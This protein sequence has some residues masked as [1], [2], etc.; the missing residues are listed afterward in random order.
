MAEFFNRLS[1]NG[2]SEDRLPCPTVVEGDALPDVTRFKGP[3]RLPDSPEDMSGLRAWD[4]GAEQPPPGDLAARESPPGNDGYNASFRKLGQLDRSGEDG[5]PA[6]FS[7]NRFLVSRY[8]LPSSAAGECSPSQDS[9]QRSSAECQH[10]EGR[11]GYTD[12]SSAS[13]S[14]LEC[15]PGG[16]SAWKSPPGSWQPRTIAR[17]GRFQRT[18]TIVSESVPSRTA[19]SRCNPLR[20]VALGFPQS[21]VQAAIHETAVGKVCSR[22]RVSGN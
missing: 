7:W 13:T 19:R 16:S 5:P 1:A 14:L 9:Q 6:L 2:P 11:A 18:R 3:G 17:P 12:G 8:R 20:A 21:D 15:D 22:S 10:L 4:A